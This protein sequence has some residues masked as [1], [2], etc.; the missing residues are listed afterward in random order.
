[1]DLCMYYASTNRHVLSHSQIL[2][3]SA[4]VVVGLAAFFSMLN[5]WCQVSH[6]LILWCSSP[7]RLPCYCQIS[8]PG[9]T[10]LRNLAQ[11][12]VSD[13]P[14]MS[15]S[16]CFR[17]E[18]DNSSVGE[19]EHFEMRHFWAAVLDWQVWLHIL[20]YMSIIAP[21]KSSSNWVHCVGSEPLFQYME[22]PCSFRKFVEFLTF[23]HLW[24]PL[25]RTII[26]AWVSTKST[27]AGTHV[28]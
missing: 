2:E 10:C 11:K 16:W 27:Y 20:I 17:Q 21:C 14:I 22:L 6:T 13:K 23:W 28:M 24:H 3:G 26:N 18:Y 12:W 1:M 7:S 4:T 8:D 5:S 15:R 9:R 25:W 19:E